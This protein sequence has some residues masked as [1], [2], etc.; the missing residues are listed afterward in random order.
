MQD[1]EKDYP[2][3]ETNSINIVFEFEQII[4]D[5]NITCG[6]NHFVLRKWLVPSLNFIITLLPVK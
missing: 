3:F 1:V 2:F 4:F 5:F 6:E